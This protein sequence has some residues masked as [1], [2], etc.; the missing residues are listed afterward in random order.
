MDFYVTIP[1]GPTT[2]MPDLQANWVDLNFEKSIQ[3]EGEYEVALVQSVFQDVF[4]G[5]LATINIFPSTLGMEMFSFELFAK[6]G[7]PVQ[8]IVERL[9]QN[10]FDEFYSKNI[11]VPTAK[12]NESTMELSFESAEGCQIFITNVDQNHININDSIHKFKNKY[13]YHLRHFYVFSNLVSSQTVGSNQSSP[14]LTNFCLNEIKS[15][16][17]Q[18]SH[19][20]PRYIKLKDNNIKNLNIE[21]SSSINSGTYLSGHIISTLHFRKKNGF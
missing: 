20:S 21:Y 5:S 7:E 6:D 2:D 8:K 13:F 19:I 3:L 9:N 12:F 16:C 15:N 1:S 14:L 18:Y 17:V 11:Q 4:T 10:I